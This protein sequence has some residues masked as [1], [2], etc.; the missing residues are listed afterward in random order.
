MPHASEVY[1]QPGNVPKG[2]IKN[3]IHRWEFIATI[4]T[5]YL[6]Y[7]R[8]LKKVEELNEQSQQWYNNLLSLEHINSLQMDWDAVSQDK[9]IRFHGR[10]KRGPKFW[11]GN[12][13][14]CHCWREQAIGIAVPTIKATVLLTPSQGANIG[15]WF[16]NSA[17][18]SLG[19]SLQPPTK[20]YETDVESALL[21]QPKCSTLSILHLKILNKISFEVFIFQ[22]GSQRVCLYF[23]CEGQSE[24]GESPWTVPVGV[25]CP[26]CCHWQWDRRD[27]LR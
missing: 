23:P 6:K 16:S 17:P 18:Q 4:F 7:L 9:K 11:N 20:S 24:S 26:V 15:Q 21:L 10:S 19:W 22:D 3:T 25:S 14:A 2:I 1:P 13:T 8:D 5:E 27:N 12:K